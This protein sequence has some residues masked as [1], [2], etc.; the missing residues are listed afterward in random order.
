MS[1]SDSALKMVGNKV[2][3]TFRRQGNRSAVV[4]PPNE[5]ET[6]NRIELPLGNPWP[7][8]AGRSTCAQNARMFQKKD[9]MRVQNENRSFRSRRVGPAADKPRRP[10]NG[11]RTATHRRVDN[12]A[13]C[14]HW[15]AGARVARWSHPTENSE[16]EPG[17]TS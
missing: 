11:R 1:D 16:S 8:P 7:A 14:T 10:T 5:G 12:P 3:G 13:K 17:I 15:W 2:S 4:P 9:L 6:L